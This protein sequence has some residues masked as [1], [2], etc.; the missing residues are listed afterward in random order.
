M[1]HM[2]CLEE[3]VGGFTAAMS[4]CDTILSGRGA[5]LLARVHGARLARAAVFE[6]A[7]MGGRCAA[8]PALFVVSTVWDFRGGMMVRCQAQGGQLASP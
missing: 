7:V 6:A 4:A 5:F 3:R 2:G 8:L 1:L